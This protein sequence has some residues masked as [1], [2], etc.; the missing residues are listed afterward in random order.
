VALERGPIVYCLE[1]VDN[2]GEVFDA[3]VPA[4]ASIAARHRPDLMGG[5]TILEVDGALR[6]GRDDAGAVVQKPGRLLAI[7]YAFWNNRGLAK[8]TVWMPRDPSG[9]R[10]PPLPT[11]AS[12]SKVSVSFSRNGMDPRRLNDQVTPRTAAERDR[13]PNFDFWP[14]KGTAEWVQYDFEKPTRVSAI[15]VY[16]FDDTGRG[17]CRLPVSWRLLYRTAEGQ[18]Q[19]AGGQPKYDI[20]KTDPVKVSFEPVTTTALRM[21][22]QL[23]QDFSA[24]LYE[25]EVE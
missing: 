9:A 4:A 23:P 10:L 2:D 14:H 6:V 17:E 21:E 5:I 13:A 25:W 20:V 1:G 11:I 16:W 12:K 7:P 15:T 24:G 19:P 22:V 18:W 3:V 8:M